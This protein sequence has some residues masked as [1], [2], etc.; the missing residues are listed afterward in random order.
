MSTKIRGKKRTQFPVPPEGL[1]QAV[2]VDAWDVW[3]EPRPEAWGGGIM[4][5]T[6][7]VWQVNKLNR[8]TGKPYE[9]S[10]KYTASLH[11]KAKLRQHL[12]SWRNKKFSEEELREF[13]IENV[14]GAGCQI[15]II[16]NIGSDGI[17]Y[18]NVTAVVPLAPGMVRMRPSKDFVR[19][20]DRKPPQDERRPAVQP[21]EAD[22]EYQPDDSDVPF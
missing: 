20:K 19:K 4:D 2:C 15:Q 11:E 6:R 10:Q 7:L 22:A 5:L 3:T 12:E 14:V 16:H 17:V 9:V 21:H 13:D 18:A 1:H 8:E